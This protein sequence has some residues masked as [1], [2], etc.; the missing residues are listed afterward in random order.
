MS[1]DCHGPEW[2]ATQKKLQ[3][4]SEVNPED[5][6]ESAA[7]FIAAFA[8]I[9]NQVHQTAIDKGWWEKDR[10]FGEMIALMH[11]ELS[12]ALEGDRNGDP[13]SEHIPMFSAVEEEL[14]DVIIRAMDMSRA[15]NYR[16]AP[17]IIA[18]MMFNAGRPHKHGGKKY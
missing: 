11:S 3:A 16:V 5:V 14:A 7:G 18:K 15:M 17:A 13:P 10:N 4:A 8:D 2:E 6:P 1:E 9:A 12:E